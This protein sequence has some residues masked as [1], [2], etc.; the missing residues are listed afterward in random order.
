MV[1]RRDGLKMKGGLL[2]VGSGGGDW[3]TEVGCS[4]SAED[5]EGVTTADQTR[6]LAR[7]SQYAET[8]VELM[9]GEEEFQGK[10][11]AVIR[12]DGRQRDEVIQ[13]SQ[14]MN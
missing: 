7:V 14:L 5:S 3:R 4:E 6:G 13:T 9:G 10:G 11:D 12:Q 1:S 2:V 8:G